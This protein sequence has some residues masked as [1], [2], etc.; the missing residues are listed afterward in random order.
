MS[1]AE[2][3]NGVE[4]GLIYGITAIGIF[5]TF[6]L[7]DFP[8]MTCDGSFVLGAAICTISIKSGQDPR[9]ALAVATVGGAVA[10]LFT[11]IIHV[12]FRVSSLL[13]GILNAFML[14]SIN[15]RIMGGIPNISLAADST[16]FYG[17]NAAITL[18]V[19]CL[20]VSGIF[21]YLFATDFG[22]GIRSIGQNKTV[23]A[24]YGINTQLMTTI[25]LVLSNA[26]IAMSGGIFCQHQCFADVAQGTGTLVIGLAAVMIG[27]KLMP[28][29]T[30]FISIPACVIGSI[31]HRLFI[32]FALH[33]E[34]LGLET[35]DLNLI[36]GWLIVAAM[37]M[38]KI[39]K[40]KRN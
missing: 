7:I 32:G 28:S 24:N 25:A 19:I 21:I 10:G 11:G 5:L 2:I 30:Y 29:R 18:S 1:G 13:S 12:F 23:A 8:D 3:V 40:K 14:Y 37:V 26:L 15:I 35:H 36:T 4:I 34:V 20:A 38:P 33:G 9:L 6:R 22:L 16:I 39:R 17:T 31:A 27:E